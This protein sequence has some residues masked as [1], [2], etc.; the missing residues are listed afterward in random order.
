M[1]SFLREQGLEDSTGQTGSEAS[2][3]A[4]EE[5]YLTV[6][7]NTQKAR[8]STILL[9]VMLLAGLLCIFF[10]VRKTT[11]QSA[12]AAPSDTNELEIAKAISHLTGVKSEVF[13][14]MDEIV[15]KFYEFSQVPQVKVNEL[16]KNPFELE[17]FMAGLGPRVNEAEPV[18]KIDPE[19]IRRQQMQKQA[20]EL[21]LMSIMRSENGN[22]CMIDGKILYRG[23]TVGKF[24]IAEIASN[25]VRLRWNPKDN[26]AR[27]GSDPENDQVILKLSE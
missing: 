13:N 7:T 20:G 22:C 24:T 25:F 2:G 3:R 8:R 26:S 21:Q 16:A 27:T 12:D 4:G 17:L 11:P 9:G 10:M 5:E 19:L 23:D 6:A 18:V 15:S 1:L 14:R